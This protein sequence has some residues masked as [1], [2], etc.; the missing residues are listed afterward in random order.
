MKIPILPACPLN[1]KQIGNQKTPIRVITDQD[2][3]K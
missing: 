3:A 2:Q 1:T